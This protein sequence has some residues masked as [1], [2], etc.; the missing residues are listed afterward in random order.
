M[1]DRLGCRSDFTR[2]LKL[3]P[4][5]AG[6][7]LVFTLPAESL[8]RLAHG[9]AD[10]ASSTRKFV[11]DVSSGS[12]R[13]DNF[14]VRCAEYGKKGE[15]CYT[16][17][18]HEPHRQGDRGGCCLYSSMESRSSVRRQRRGNEGGRSLSVEEGSADE[19]GRGWKKSER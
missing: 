7:K 19:G 15:A 4:H 10:I 5:T 11:G 2:N 17:A 3:R 13:T 12:S 9:S 8:A 14:R 18:H 6:R 1:G 16:L